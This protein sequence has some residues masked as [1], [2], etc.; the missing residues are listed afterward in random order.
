MTR[1]PA[2]ST[3][4][5][6]VMGITLV[7]VPTVIYGGMAILGLLTEGMAGLDLGLTLSPDQRALYRAGHAHAGVLIIFSLLLQ[8]V[9]D[10][11]RLPRRVRWFA[12]A[13]A[14]ASPILLPGGFFGMAHHP[15][16]AYLAYGGAACLAVGTVSAGWG[17]LRPPE[18]R[19]S[20]FAARP[21]EPPSS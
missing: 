2:F 14:A 21:G 7:T 15:S 20:S 4:A 18:P 19:P 10:G 12:R 5:R 3:E 6:T 17:L 16:F 13:T 8:M 9:L 11:A 1:E